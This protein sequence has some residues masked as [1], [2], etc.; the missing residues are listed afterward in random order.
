VHAGARVVLV[1]GIV[2]AGV[3]VIA[4]GRAHAGTLPVALIALR[5]GEA[6]VT[7]R[8]RRDGGEDAEQERVAGIRGALEEV[9]AQ[10]ARS[11]TAA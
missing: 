6:V 11:I 10:I 5:A 2:R 7:A 1:A 4:E 3:S 9:V 8:P